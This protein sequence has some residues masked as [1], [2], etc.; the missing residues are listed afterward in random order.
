MQNKDVIS[1]A[2]KYITTLFE[3]DCG[4]HSRSMEDS[5]QHFHDKLLL[6]CDEMN[7]H[8]AKSIAKVRHDFMVAFLEE[9]EKEI[10]IK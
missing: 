4:G 3:G 5:I 8:A 7:T 1:E 10:I 2:K 9:F 6:L